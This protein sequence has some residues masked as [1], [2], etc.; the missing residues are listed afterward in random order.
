MATPD[1]RADKVAA[2]RRRIAEGT[3]IVRA[4]VIAW[5]MLEARG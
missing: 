3:Y 2:A 1:V 4:D 5:R